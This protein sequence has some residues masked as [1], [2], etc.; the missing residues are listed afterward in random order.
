MKVTDRSII[1][2]LRPPVYIVVLLP[3]LR[4]IHHPDV[5]A[6]RGT[7]RRK[8]SESSELFC[9]SLSPFRSLSLRVC[10]SS[11]PLSFSFSLSSYSFSSLS[12]ASTHNFTFKFTLPHTLSSPF[13]PALITTASRLSFSTHDTTTVMKSR[14]YMR[15]I[16]HHRRQKTRSSPHIIYKRY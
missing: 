9:L 1:H 2:H 7:T 13:H 15:H 8:A 10:L 16:C 5:R 12:H 3:R 6:R 4:R 14:Q 11:F